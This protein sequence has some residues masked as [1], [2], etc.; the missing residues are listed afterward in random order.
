MSDR[1]LELLHKQQEIGSHLVFPSIRGKIL[2]DMFLTQFLRRHKAKS[3]DPDRF[4]VAHG[5]RSS[6]RNWASENAYSRD[7]A[8]RALAHTIKDKTESAYHR[9]N[10]LEERRPMMQKWADFLAAP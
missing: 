1:A 3:D 5:F 8:E 7:L 9:T 4:A 6:F 2:S 10:L